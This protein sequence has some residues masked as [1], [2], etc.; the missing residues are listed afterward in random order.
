MCSFTLLGL[1]RLTRLPRV[2]KTTMMSTSPMMKTKTTVPML[3]KN[4]EGRRSRRRKR[5]SSL[6]P[7]PP[8]SDLKVVVSC[9]TSCAYIQSHITLAAPAR[10]AS[11]SDSDSEY[12]SR[13]KK[14]KKSRSS[15]DEIRVSSRGGKVPNYIDDI[16]DFGQ[17]EDEEA[18]ATYYVDPNVKEEDEI[19][20]VL[21]HTR[22]E[23][24]EEDPEDLWFDNVVC[25]SFLF[26][27]RQVFTVSHSAFPHQMEK[28]FPPTQHGR[29]LRVPKAI[30]R[31]KESRQLHQILQGLPIEA[32]I[33]WIV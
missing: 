25:A 16:Q 1:R 33:S 18:E 19:E 31:P 15:G 23:G 5:R 29:N 14:K 20:A 28:L 7:R 4:T 13:S 6:R 21:T 22:D 3:M 2:M 8:Q 17:F 27:P 12:G 30:Q 24:R 32:L 26:C 10:H 9:R 11:T